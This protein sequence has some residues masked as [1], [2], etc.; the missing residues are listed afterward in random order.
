MDLWIDIQIHK[1]IYAGWAVMYVISLFLLFKNRNNWDIK[2]KKV[3]TLIGLSILLFFC[4]LTVKII[5]GNILPGPWEYE[6][7]TWIFFVAPVISYTF[8]K[9][10]DGLRRRQ[11]IKGIVAFVVLCFILGAS[12]LFTRAYKETENIN[13]VPDYALEISDAI[14]EDCGCY[15]GELYGV[16]Q[17]AKDDKGYR[18]KP[19]VLIQ[20]DENYNSDIGDEMKYG[21]R[22]YASALI[23]SEIVIPKLDYDSSS[24][25]I[26]KFVNLNNYEY[27]V[28]TNNPYLRKQVENYGFKPLKEIGDYVIYKNTKEITLYFVRHGE[29][30]ANANGIYSGSMTDTK[31][32]DKGIADAKKAGNALQDITFDKVYVS[33]LSRS[34]DTAKYIIGE[35]N[36]KVPAVSVMKLLNDANLGALEG[37]SREEVAERYPDFSEE[38][39]FGTIS[40]SKF[41]SPIGATSKNKVTQN[42]KTALDKMVTEM[43]NDSKALIVGHSA[44]VW[45][46][47]AVFPNEVSEEAVLDNASITV[48]K[49]NKGKYEIEAYNTDASQFKEIEQ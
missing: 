41:V 11:R 48:L 17:V 5:L 35:N 37:L 42:Y 44:F 27:F 22:Q 24:F 8:M 38:K 2:I 23:L 34:N 16:R 40:D 31:L 45:F 10:I 29:T 33:E 21:I 26:S 14:A 12:P 6:R 19:K 36:N 15:D 20:F 46:L 1:W 4:P 13:K 25:K 18:I 47:Q 39:F 30:S 43:S 49:Y 3:I 28:C 7:L 9:V 32:T